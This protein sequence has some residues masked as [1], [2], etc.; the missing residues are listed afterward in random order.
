MHTTPDG[1]AWRIVHIKGVQY[2]ELLNVP[3][4]RRLLTTDLR[5]MSPPV[6]P[7]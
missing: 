3:P 7:R 2:A 4:M 5:G 1:R 6:E